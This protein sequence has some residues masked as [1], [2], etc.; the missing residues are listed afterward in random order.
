MT[1]KIVNL[2]RT[3]DAIAHLSEALHLLNQALDGKKSEWQ[4]KEE[5]YKADIADNA[6][7]LEMLKTSSQKVV[8]NINQVMLKLDNVLKN[9]GASNSN[10]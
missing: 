2:P 7:R 1:D 5:K 6:E 4:R 9:D 10:N 3:G 8:N